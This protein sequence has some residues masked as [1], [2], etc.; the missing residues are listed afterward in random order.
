MTQIDFNTLFNNTPEISAVPAG[1]YHVV[2]ESAEAVKT[3]QTDLPMLKL[4]LSIVGGPQNN[5]KLFDNINV[6]SRDE[7]KAPVVQRFFFRKMAAFGL[8]FQE[9]LS[10]NPTMEQLAQAIVGRQA[11]VTVKIEQWNGEDQS[12]VSGYAKAGAVSATGPAAP[13]VA[14]G[15]PTG[16]PA[17][18]PTAAPVFPT[19]APV[20][21]PVPAAAVPV[22]AVAAPVPAA[23]TPVAAP[24]APVPAPVT[25][26]PAPAVPAPAPVPVAPPAAEAPTQL[27]VQVPGVAPVAPPVAPVPEGYTPP[28]PPAAS[29]I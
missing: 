1:K 27:P 5:R 17:A 9:Y 23:A 6:T 2:V 12:R 10:Q 18:V 20:A 29:F 14:P 15:S 11:E 21:A 25:V 28:E 8:G 16:I 13:V 7:N 22:P 19:A 24:A 4:S 26:A 3:K